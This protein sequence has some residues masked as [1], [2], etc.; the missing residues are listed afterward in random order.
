MGRHRRSEAGE[1]DAAHA[2][3]ARSARARGRRR[4]IRLPRRA[5]TVSARLD[6]GGRARVDVPACARAA[7]AVV[8]VSDGDEPPTAEVATR[9]GVKLVRLAPARGANAARNAGAGAADGNLLVFVDD[10]IEASD[11]WL[12]ALLAGAE[13]AE[14]HD[15]FG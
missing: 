9:H 13:S 14:G 10:D 4:R 12:A 1:V 5:R 6:A 7:A 8:V 2:G 3:Q 11:G 15:A